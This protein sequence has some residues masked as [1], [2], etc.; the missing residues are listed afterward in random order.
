[1]R[2]SIDITLLQ[3][4]P[5]QHNVCIYK[6]YK[7]TLHKQGIEWCI[8]KYINDP[9]IFQVEV[10]TKNVCIIRNSLEN[11]HLRKYL[12][13]LLGVEFGTCTHT[14][15]VTNERNITIATISVDILSNVCYTQALFQFAW[16]FEELGTLPSIDKH[17][18]EMTLLYSV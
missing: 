12:S 7:I 17:T 11:E 3:T 8:I 5:L 6:Q 2:Q 15:I 10:L 1:M 18:D 14:Y 13:N 16:H 4:K 9:F